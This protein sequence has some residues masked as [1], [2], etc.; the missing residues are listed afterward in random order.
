MDYVLFERKHMSCVDCKDADPSGLPFKLHH[1][2]DLI[3]R[4][5]SLFPPSP[6]LVWIDYCLLHF[7]N[8]LCLALPQLLYHCAIIMCP[9]SDREQFGGMD[10]DTPIFTTSVPNTVSCTSQEVN[11]WLTKGL[12]WSFELSFRFLMSYLY[13]SFKCI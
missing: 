6:C 2:L 10:H 9:I 13:I 8:N 1:L 4:I 12:H 3:F 5:D 11:I 7:S